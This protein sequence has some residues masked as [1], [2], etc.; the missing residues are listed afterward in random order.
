MTLA[1][2]GVLAMM[3]TSAPSARSLSSLGSVVR[4]GKALK[5]W[6]AST[7][8]AESSATIL[9]GTERGSSRA[10]FTGAPFV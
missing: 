8:G 7:S 5:L 2:N 9:S 4:V 6:P 1:G 10:M 3:T